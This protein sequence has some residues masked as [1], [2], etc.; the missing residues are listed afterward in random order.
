MLPSELFDRLE[1][2]L[3]I[4]D[5]LVW[6]LENYPQ[7]GLGELVRAYGRV[8]LDETK[9][10]HFGDIARRYTSDDVTLVARP[11]RLEKIV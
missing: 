2:A 4:D 9:T 10:M 7:V 3:P 5:L 6:L 11:M 8:F 1:S